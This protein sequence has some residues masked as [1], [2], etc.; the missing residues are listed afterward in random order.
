MKDILKVRIDK[1]DSLFSLSYEVDH[2]VLQKLTEERL[3]KTV[4][5]TD[6]L[7]WTPHQVIESYRNLAFIEES[8]KNMKNLHFLRWQPAFHWTDQKL[9]VHGFYSVLAL[10][11]CS[12]ASKIVKEAGVKMTIPA[13]L[14][15]LSSIR[16]VALFY[17]TE[18][19]IKSHITLSR[20]SP[21]QKKLAELLEIHK[22]MAVG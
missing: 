9:R 6:Q 21:R 12:L 7:G 14:K 13:L 18:A 1:M 5:V 8:F 2:A 4:L 19:Q 20:M 10:L 22:I 11:L 15:E 17:P 3:G 16:E